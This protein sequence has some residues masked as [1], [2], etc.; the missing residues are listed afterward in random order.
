RYVA[1]TRPG[2]GQQVVEI[3]G[4]LL[5]LVRRELP[6]A[7]AVRMRLRTGD[8]RDVLGRL[9]AAAFDLVVVDVYAGG[10]MPA[11]LASVEF[12]AL[13]AGVLRPGGVLAVNLADG[14]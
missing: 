8:A 13:A 11:R 9:P 3:D 12:A 4:P 14:D 5:D 7:R 1:A 10:R 6:L 2:S